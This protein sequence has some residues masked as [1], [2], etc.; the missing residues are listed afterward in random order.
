MRSISATLIRVKDKAKIRFNLLQNAALNAAALDDYLGAS[1]IFVVIGVAVSVG[2]YVLATVNTQISLTTNT[3]TAGN[4]I[5]PTT[6]LCSAGT[7]VTQST[8]YNAAG[9]AVS[10]MNTFAQWLPILAIV[11][12]AVVIIALLYGFFRGGT[13]K[14]P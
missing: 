5:S 13:G 3:C 12:V 9:Q 1:V 2:V 10:G 11:L 7:F 6:G 8:A 14:A 4:T